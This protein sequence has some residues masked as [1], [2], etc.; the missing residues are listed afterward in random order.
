MRMFQGVSLSPLLLCIVLI[1]LTHELNRAD[2]GYQVHG[3]KTKIN[4]LLYMDNLKLLSRSE[5]DLKK[6]IKVVKAIGKDINMN[7][8]LD[9]WQIFVKK[10]RV[11]W[12]ICVESVCEKDIKELDSRKA[13]K[14]LGIA[15]SHVIDYKN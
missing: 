4:H 7:F 12:K 11:Q 2:C 13:Y 1:L 3:D 14:N 9:K 5:E 10:G 15:D 8:G 6:E